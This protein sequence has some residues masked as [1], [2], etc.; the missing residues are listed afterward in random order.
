M[1]QIFKTFVDHMNNAKWQLINKIMYFNKRS[2][3]T[4][5]N[6]NNASFQMK[7]CPIFY[8]LSDYDGEL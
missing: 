6:E 8:G 1:M 3:V 2:K 5:N 4:V 7:A